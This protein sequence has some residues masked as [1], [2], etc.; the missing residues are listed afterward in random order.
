MKE[1][2]SVPEVFGDDGMGNAWF[3]PAAQRPESRHAVDVIIELA[4]C[5]AGELE[6]IALAPLTN[7]AVAFSRDPSIAQKIK[8]IYYM[9][10]CLYAK[11]NITMGAEYNAWADPEAT[12][13]VFRSGANLVLTPWEVAKDFAYINEDE[14]ARIAALD[15]ATSRFYMQVTRV[16][17]E[18]TR[19]IEDV[20]GI[21]HADCIGMVV[22]LYP[23]VITQQRRM[24]VDIELGGELSRGVTYLDWV[25][26]AG[27]RPNMNVV[28]ATDRQAFVDAMFEFVR[29]R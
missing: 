8:A 5:H 20:P 23:Q 22:P 3:P 10:G 14:R 21:I 29:R 28:L 12:R 13:V 2:R 17:H 4:H 26:L 11:G 7:L 27:K 18:Y 16:L 24:Y 15:T 9:G 19:A 1:Y 25:G 6:I